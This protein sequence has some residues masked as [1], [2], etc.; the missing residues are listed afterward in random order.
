M[1]P[2][3]EKIY[4]GEQPLYKKSIRLDWSNGRLHEVVI[5]GNGNVDD[6]RTALL[7]LAELIGNDPNLKV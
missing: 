6:V 7:R 3:I 1:E 2:C 5:Q 4:Q